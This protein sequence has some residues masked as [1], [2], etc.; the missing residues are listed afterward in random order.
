[1]SLHILCCDVRYDLR[2]E[3]TFGWSLPPECSYLI[4][5]IS[6]CLP[7]MVSNT[8]RVMFCFSS[9]C[10]SW[11]PLQYS[12]T[13]ICPFLW[14]VHFWL[15]LRYSLTFIC[16]FLWIVHFWLPL[17][18]SLTFIHINCVSL[19]CAFNVPYIFKWY[20]GYLQFKA[21]SSC[22]FVI[23]RYLGLSGQ[24]GINISWTPGGI[25]QRPTTNTFCG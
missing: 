16:Q 1:M 13:F 15:P 23:S 11:L 20:I 22:S 14:I 21:F 17:R 24:N 2:I 3:T 12:L 5:L 25:I 18:Y 7:N 10:V 19:Y 9:S 6:V 4:Y 8:Y